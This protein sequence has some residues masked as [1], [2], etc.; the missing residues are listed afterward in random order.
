V[1]DPR[2]LPLGLFNPCG[3]GLL[4][5]VAGVKPSCEAII[6]VEAWNPLIPKRDVVPLMPVVGA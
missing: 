6:V 4:R 3:N 5:R 2:E 1:A